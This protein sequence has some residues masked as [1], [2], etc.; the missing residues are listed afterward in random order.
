MAL[1]L[2]LAAV[3]GGAVRTAAALTS[4]DPDP[5]PTQIK[6]SLARLH[7]HLEPGDQGFR[8]PTSSMEPT[9][10][11]ARPGAECLAAV[12]DRLVS[13][14]YA[15][16]QSPRRGDLVPFLVPQLAVIRCGAGGTFLKR[17][18]GLPGDTVA[19]KSGFMYVNGKRL[20]EPYVQADRR[21]ERTIAAVK[22][23]AGRFY[24]MG[25]NRS[26]SCDSRSWGTVPRRNI[27]G[28]I[29]AIYWPAKRARLIP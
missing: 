1:V 28:R 10:H 6:A 17:V 16:G 8:M 9:L 19:E 25:D 5:T 2:A 26:S 11:C 18:I 23:P 22:I 3:V 4:S 24:V 12:A 21:D 15:V 29:Y 20:A 14:P 13:R 7:E 27:L